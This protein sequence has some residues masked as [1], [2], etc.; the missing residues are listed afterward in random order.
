MSLFSFEEICL[1]E[2]GVCKYAH[3]HTCEDCYSKGIHFCHCEL[4][5]ESFVN[6]LNGTCDEADYVTSVAQLWIKSL[7]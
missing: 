6:H 5:N 1:S 3:Y 2:K 4:S 7:E